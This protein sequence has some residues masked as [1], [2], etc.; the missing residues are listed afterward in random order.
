M[1]K[2]HHDANDIQILFFQEDITR[3]IDET[4]LIEYEISFYNGIFISNLIHKLET[5]FLSTQTLNANL[6]DFESKHRKIKKELKQFQHSSQIVNECDDLSCET[7][8]LNDTAKF[9][10]KIESHFAD[11]RTLKKEVLL[12]LNSGLLK[13]MN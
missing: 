10:T 9:K 3:W 4:E 2:K 5:D 7:H 12:Y 11:Y 6:L 13:Y 1:I 8:F